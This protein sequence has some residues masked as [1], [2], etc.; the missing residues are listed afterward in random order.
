MTSSLL[1]GAFFVGAAAALASVA[2]AEVHLV[3]SNGFG[4]FTDAQAAIDA[5]LDGDTIYL[6]RPPYVQYD[7]DA[8]SPVTIDGKSLT[9][10]AAPGVGVGV[11]SLTVRGLAEGQTVVLSDITVYDEVIFE[12][13][14]G[15]VLAERCQLITDLYIYQYDDVVPCVVRDSR[16]IVFNGFSSRVGATDKAGPG[17]PGVDTRRSR[18][19]LYDVTITGGEGND[20]CQFPT[21]VPPGEG[22]PGLRADGGTVFL[23]QSTV[24]GGLG[25]WDHY[26]CGGDEPAADGGPGASVAASA[27]VTAVD[28]R[29]IGGDGGYSYSSPGL[30]GADYEGDIDFLP[31]YSPLLDAPARGLE[32]RTATVTLQGRPLDRATL[33]VGQSA[34]PR[35]SNSGGVLLPAAPQS[36][37]LGSFPSSG[38]LTYELALPDAPAQGAVGLFLQAEVVTPRACTT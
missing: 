1:P 29:F 36:I 24:T 22:G 33:L 28:T 2:S 26:Y 4:D 15:V 14:R 34:D 17:G 21:T 16:W 32:G 13:N 5:A 3:D 6:Q 35:R 11:Q 18:V 27:S 31:G 25:G 9:L 23:A 38:E 8:Y 30:P 37:F 19:F 7:N 10:A 20:P 12:N